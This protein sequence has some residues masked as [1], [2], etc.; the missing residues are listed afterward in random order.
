MQLSSSNQPDELQTALNTIQ[1]HVDQVHVL[2]ARN[3]EL[4]AENK[5]LKERANNEEETSWEL[6][7]YNENLE[8]QVKELKAERDELQDKLH[9]IRRLSGVAML[10][11]DE[12]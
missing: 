7:E 10:D 4:T 12:A 11:N 3:T 6:K 2:R 8:A 9:K 5:T 1:S